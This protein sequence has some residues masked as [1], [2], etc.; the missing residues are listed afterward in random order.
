MKPLSLATTVRGAEGLR[1]MIGQLY[2][3]NSQPSMAI[4]PFVGELGE[5]ALYD[6]ALTQAEITKHI[7]LALTEPT[8]NVSW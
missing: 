7:A 2:S 5:V 3:L 4:R 1:V 8:S 6:R